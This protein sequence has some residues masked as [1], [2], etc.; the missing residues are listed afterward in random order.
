MNKMTEINDKNSLSIRKCIN[1]FNINKDFYTNTIKDGQID[2]EKYY[3]REMKMFLDSR[4]ASLKKI[5]AREEF[6]NETRKKNARRY[7]HVESVLF[8]KIK[9]IP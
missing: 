6:Q 9:G 4:S 1:R 2:A 8:G 5:N 7:S 3:D